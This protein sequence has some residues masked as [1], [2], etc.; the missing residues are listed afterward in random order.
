[1]GGTRPHG[2]GVPF[3]GQAGVPHA[4]SALQVLL[5]ARVAGG[6]AWRNTRTFSPYSA[7]QLPAWLDIPPPT[8]YNG[9][10]H[11][12]TAPAKGLVAL[13]KGGGGFLAAGGGFANLLDC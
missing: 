3:A 13:P 12:Q 5:Q 1:M 11:L 10:G 9:Y 7:L 4:Q 2:H 6:A 8:F